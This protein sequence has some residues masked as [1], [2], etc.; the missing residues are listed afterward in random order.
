MVLLDVS[1][2]NFFQKRTFDHFN[3]ILFKRLS[4][5]ILFSNFVYLLLDRITYTY[6]RLL[7]LT[8]KYDELGI[9]VKTTVFGKM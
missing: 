1:S 2:N 8:N 6:R 9:A 3:L 4:C 5:E 7:A